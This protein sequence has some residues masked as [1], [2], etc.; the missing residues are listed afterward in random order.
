MPRRARMSSSAALISPSGRRDVTS[1]SR[2][3][4]PAR[5]SASRPRDV[6]Q[7][8][9]AAERAAHHLLLGEREQAGG[10]DRDRLV[11]RRGT[12]AHRRATVAD[13]GEAPLDQARPPDR[14]KA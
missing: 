8:V 13:G 11:D 7:R 2:S 5:Q 6:A 10:R 12:D 1:A 14:S 4:R 9:R 3:S